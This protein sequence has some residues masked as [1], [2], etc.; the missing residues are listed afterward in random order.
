MTPDPAS[1][2]KRNGSEP[3]FVADVMLGSL[4]KSLRMLGHDV[5]YSA[6]ASDSELK[7]TAIREGRVLLTRDRELA[8][9]GLTGRAVLIESDHL[10]E[11]LRQVALEFG[12]SVGERL[13]TRCLVCNTPVEEIPRPSVKG[14]VPEYVYATQSGFVRCPACGRIYWSGTHVEQ[15]RA[16]LRRILGEKEFPDGSGSGQ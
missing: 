8:G 1:A 14:L 9:S 11:Q 7:L 10:D 13:F 12:L 15:A 2:D 16:R 6:D 5:Q 4:A 3:R